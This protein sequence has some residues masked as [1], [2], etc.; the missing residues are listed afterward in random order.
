MNTTVGALLIPVRCLLQ[1][2]IFRKKKKKKNQ[3]SSLT[4]SFKKLDLSRLTRD[5]DNMQLSFLIVHFSLF[6]LKLTEK[7]HLGWIG[8]FFFL[9]LN[10]THIDKDVV[11]KVVVL[12]M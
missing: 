2:G 3:S 1:R 9:K 4:F 8:A 11:I 6:L 7:M 10:G 12:L 5:C